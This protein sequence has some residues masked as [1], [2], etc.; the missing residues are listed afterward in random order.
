MNNRLRS[1]D[2]SC[3]ASCPGDI[4]TTT[5]AYD[6]SKGYCL[7]CLAWNYACTMALHEAYEA[8]VDNSHLR[9]VAPMHGTQG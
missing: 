5:A 6:R 3:R 1:S 9:C 2:A 8:C 4:S 7:G